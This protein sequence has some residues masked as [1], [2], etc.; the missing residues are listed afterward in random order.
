[1]SKTIILGGGFA[2]LFTALHLLKHQ[3]SQSIALVDRKEYFVFNPLLYELMTGEMTPDEVCPT[4]PELF[5][6]QQSIAFLQETVTGVD[7]KERQV[8][9]ESGVHYKYENLVLA[10]G[11]PA[12]FFGVE[13][14]QESAFPLKDREHARRLSL[15]VRLCLEK[16]AQTDDV[17]E[18]RALLTF[19][20]VGGGPAGIEMAATLGDLLM[21][22]YTK[23]EGDIQ[24]IRILLINR[25]KEL[26]KGDV[27][28][29]LRG[30]VQKALSSRKIPTELIL[31]ASASK[32]TPT[33]LDY[34]QDGQTHS[35]PTRT[36]IWTAGT[37]P[38]P[39]IDALEITPEHKPRKGI[40]SVLPTLQLP[41]YPE[42]FA[43]GDCAIL[44]DSPLPPTAQVAYQQGKAIAD[45]LQA[46]AQDR[47]LKPAR[48]SLRGTMM[49]LGIETSVA[50]IFDRREVG[51]RPGHL[52]REA[53]YLELMPTPVHN[54]K[55]TADWIVDEIFHRHA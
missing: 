13:G 26:L 39:I 29:R 15:H 44:P 4:Y 38:N 17:A 51:G 3:Y 1:M 47:P 27:N 32:V 9:L 21:S 49:K 25:P 36:V 37:S 11:K 10:L 12:G 24:D 18:R 48:V 31:G 6:G 7:L 2:G 50:N 33:S 14:A 20:I 34:Q 43:A 53:T 45:N 46:L 52:I 54:L 40:L 5:R 23:L 55:V 22:W 16:A 19:A 30:T 28:S 8:Y 41:D 35:I 42:V